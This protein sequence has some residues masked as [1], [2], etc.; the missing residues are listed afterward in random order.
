[1]EYN[2]RVI[3]VDSK[4]ISV[5]EAKLKVAREY[6]D[7]RYPDN[8]FIHH[9]YDDNDELSKLSAFCK[10]SFI[11]DKIKCMTKSIPVNQVVKVVSRE[12]SKLSSKT[13]VSLFGG[14]SKRNDQSGRD[15]LQS[16]QMLLE[17][18]IERIC[19][20]LGL[21]I[22]EK[23]MSSSSLQIVI[24]DTIPYEIY[25]K[26][27]FEAMKINIISGY[28]T[29]FGFRN[30]EDVNFETFRRNVGDNL[31]QLIREKREDIVHCFKEMLIKTKLELEKILYTLESFGKRCQPNTI[32]EC[33]YF[34]VFVLKYN[35]SFSK[36]QH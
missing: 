18:T 16:M 7:A 1:M 11:C 35:S 22:Y 23:L 3:F 26:M 36:R 12:V 24:C 9:N 29:K 31:F 4:G 17:E 25:E 14:R 15:R 27:L 20:L 32:T 5:I 30:P 21:L 6:I 19:K 13:T 33:K 28:K 10:V 8:F 34:L 2:P